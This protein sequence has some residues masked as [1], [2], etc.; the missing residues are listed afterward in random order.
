MPLDH[1]SAN[2]LRR[3]DLM[4]GR[5]IVIFSDL[6]GTLLDHE[7]YSH[8]AALP[9]L[10]RVRQLQIPLILAS[11]KTAAEIGPLRQKIGF[12]HCPAIVENGA[13]LLG[14]ARVTCPDAAEHHEETQKGR[15]EEL[16]EK[17]NQLPSHLRSGFEGF[18]QWT[19]EE[20][21][22]RTGLTEEQAALARKRQFS[23][24]G[25]WSDNEMQFALFLQALGEQGITA[26]RG[27]RFVSLSFGGNK[28]ERMLEL[29]EQ[30]AAQRNSLFVVALGDAPNDAAML[31]QADL[32]ILVKNPVGPV[33]DF[34]GMTIKGMIRTTSKPGP[35]GWNEE[36]LDILNRNATDPNPDGVSGINGSKNG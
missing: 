20:I 4:Q 35:E 7:T 26:T 34:S 5:K 9:A 32:G 10:A 29:I 22:A 1:K 8:E 28:V 14:A 27:G 33:P 36:I 30:F 25:I 3:G 12:A 17:L 2:G 16:V 31:A 21:S 11:S 13:G 6:D 23:E 24:P 15:Y 19:L 18:S